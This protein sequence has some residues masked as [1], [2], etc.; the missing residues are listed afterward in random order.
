MTEYVRVRPTNAGDEAVFRVEKVTYNAKSDKINYPDFTICG[1]DSRD[2]PVFVNIPE[3]ACRRQ[4]SRL[5]MEP[6]A[7]VGAT[8]RV[9]RGAN[10]S[11]PTKPYWNV[12]LVDASDARPRTPAK[13]LSGPP[14][15][16]NDKEGAAFA[17]ELRDDPTGA[18]GPPE[19]ID[20][21]VA[22]REPGEEP[23]TEAEA[24]EARKHASRQAAAKRYL[25]LWDVI[26]EHQVAVGKR[27]EMPVDGQS[28]NQAAATLWI[29]FGNKGM[30]P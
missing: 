16:Y 21:P 27:L 10:A 3:V 29:F 4:F 17:Q 9:S 25:A 7:C 30:I 20:Y 19:A 26:A 8:I 22:G 1:Q 12:E 24:I 23:M 11:D 5:K 6:E 28:V 18:G 13:R 15:E 2:G 14:A